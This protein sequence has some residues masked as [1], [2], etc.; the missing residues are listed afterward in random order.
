MYLLRLIALL[1]FFFLLL[2]QTVFAVA[3]YIG[4]NKCSECHMDLYTN[5]LAS[6]HHLQLRKAEKA[7]QTNLA[8]PKGYSWDDISYVIGGIK[9]K[10]YFVDQNGYI[11]TSAKDG[12]KDKTQYN[13][14]DD[15]W[16]YYFP[17]EKKPYDCGFCHTT[18]YNSNGNQGGLEGIVGTW[19]EDG[20]GCE[21][22]HGP[23]SEHIKD[24]VKRSIIRTRSEA[25]CEKCHQ[26]GGINHRPLRDLGLVRHHE[27]INELKAGPHKGLTCLNCHNPH[28][29]ASLT[30]YNCIIC[31]SRASI[32]YEKSVHGKAD[33][34]CIEC[35][36]AK[37]PKSAISRA[38][39]IGKVRKHL[40]KI[41][42][43]A[44]VS[45]FMTIEEEGKKSTFTKG[46]ITVEF[47]CLSCHGSQDKTWASKHAKGFHK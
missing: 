28:Q 25:L 12:S 29:R 1:L 17:G 27:Q 19:Y 47:A 23:G 4:S 34:K 41:N 35:H 32:D 33:I 7:Q 11:I 42:T 6:G 30:K 9:T 14:G 37:V 16:S 21:V 24:P 31:H 22:C 44:E 5:W 2:P 43:T 10:A 8:L 45:M 40:F 15:S 36:M 38:S 18:G 39:Y 13:L 20:V 3:E 26:R 46:F